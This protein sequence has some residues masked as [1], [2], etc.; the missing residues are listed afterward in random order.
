MGFN[1][2]AEV[3]GFFDAGAGKTSGEE[4]DSSKN[5]RGE[6]NPTADQLIATK[7]IPRKIYSDPF[8]AYKERRFPCIVRDIHSSSQLTYAPA[9]YSEYEYTED[10]P[11]RP[12]GWAANERPMA[13][14]EYDSVIEPPYTPDKNAFAHTS[15][16]I[17]ELVD[18]HYMERSFS[19]QNPEDL[20]KIYNIFNEYY[21]AL[22]S[23]VSSY[24]EFEHELVKAEGFW[25]FIQTEYRRYQ[26]ENKTQTFLDMLAEASR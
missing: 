4:F 3:L 9:F 15:L 25:V 17:D 13:S 7:G 11:P 12:D 21:A 6:N 14:V 26:S 16:T 19:L 10:D 22:K 23:Y 24:G 5:N 8:E 18:I 2:E 20:V 1:I